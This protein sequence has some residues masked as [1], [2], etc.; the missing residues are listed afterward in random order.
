M[1]ACT[2]KRPTIRSTRNRSLDGHFRSCR[3]AETGG[4]SPLKGY[5]RNWPG[6][7]E[8]F[9]GAGGSVMNIPSEKL[10]G[11]VKSEFDRWSEI[12]KISGIKLQ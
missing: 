3:N 10:G 8:K 11:V 2:K 5:Y 9:S 1:R 12:V 4:G 6:L 7:A